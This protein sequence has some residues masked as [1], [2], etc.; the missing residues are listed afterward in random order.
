MQVGDAIVALRFDRPPDRLPH[1]SRGL[2]IEKHAGDERSSPQDQRT[3]SV[4]PTRPMKGSSH[5]CS[6]YLPARRAKIARTE[7]KASAST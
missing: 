6:R 4:A 1:L 5:G 2:H 7:V 3:T